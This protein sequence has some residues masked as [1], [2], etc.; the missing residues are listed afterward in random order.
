MPVILMPTES[1]WNNIGPKDKILKVLPQTGNRMSISRDYAR[2]SLPPGQ[3]ISKTGKIYWE[4]R[5]N[6]T[7]ILKGR[8]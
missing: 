4:T 8:L 5:K 7:D 1:V 2:K 3:R 6:R